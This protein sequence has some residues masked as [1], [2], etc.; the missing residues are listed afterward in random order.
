M[1]HCIDL[2][3]TWLNSACNAVGGVL[4]GLLTL[5]KDTLL[6][7]RLDRLADLVGGGLAATVW[8]A[9][10]NRVM[11]HHHCIYAKE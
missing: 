4:D 9:A 5:L 7:V 6:A 11:A 8:S 3:L 1:Q 2:A 10:V